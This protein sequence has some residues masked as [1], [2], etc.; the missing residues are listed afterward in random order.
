MFSS[1][2]QDEGEDRRIKYVD[3]V[4]GE[5]MWFEVADD[6]AEVPGAVDKEDQLD[7]TNRARHMKR[8][9]PTQVKRDKPAKRRKR[10]KL[11]DE[12]KT[13][14]SE[15]KRRHKK[16]SRK[17]KHKASHKT[18]KRRHRSHKET[19]LSSTT[20]TSSS[21]SS[22]NSSSE[23][24]GEEYSTS[25]S[26]TYVAPSIMFG[27]LIGEAIPSKLKQRIW[28][29]KFINLARLLPSYTSEESQLKMKQDSN[30]R[31]YF[32][33]DR[34]QGDLNYGQWCEAFEVYMAI[35]VETQKKKTG[36]KAV[37][38]IQ[39]MLTYKKE[40]GRLYML[41][42]NWRGYDNHFRKDREARAYPWSTTRS[43]LILQYSKQVGATTQRTPMSGDK[44]TC[45][46]YHNRFAFCNDASCMF[47][48]QCNRCFR[49]HP[50]YKE[51]QSITRPVNY[52]NQQHAQQQTS[53]TPPRQGQLTYKAAMGPNSQATNYKPIT[54]Q[55]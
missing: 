31:A 54:Q 26:D 4:T 25:E 48:H 19:D 30:N 18:K 34:K 15:T 53:V 36:K 32:V 11:R 55:K 5:I 1:N 22:S 16:T 45:Y 12:H 3:H 49:N 43:D 2:D 51:C 44:T 37:K 41:G 38:M 13:N 6:K 46:K 8:S 50:M 20:D 24:S 10:R 17:H 9:T 39:Q 14:Y 35:Y 7:Q 27:M 33:K 47:S 40:V 52:N 23:E 28:K 29:N 42:Y 21:D